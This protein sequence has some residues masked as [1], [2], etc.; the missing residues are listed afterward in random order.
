MF[1]NVEYYLDRIIEDLQTPI[2]ALLPNVQFVTDDPVNIV[3]TDLP[4]ISVMP[5]TEEFIYDDSS[6][7]SDLKELKISILLRMAGTPASSL[8]SPIINQIVSTLRKDRM[9]GTSDTVYVEFQGISW[10]SDRVAEGKLCGAS[11]DILV[12]YSLP[13]E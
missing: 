3:Y 8:C 2:S 11:L 9:L 4:I 7:S 12:R 5:I 1:T 13:L 6:N 10:A